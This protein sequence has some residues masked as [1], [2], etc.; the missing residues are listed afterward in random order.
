M[1]M[2]GRN[3]S[4]TSDSYRYAYNGMEHDDEVTSEFG[5]SYTTE[6]RQYDPRL[7]RWKSLDPLMVKYP[8]MSP[9]CA[10]NN[11][12]VYFVDPDGREGQDWFENEKGEKKWIDSKENLEIEVTASGKAHVWT[13]IGEQL[14]SKTSG[15]GKRESTLFGAV[16]DPSNW[17][18]RGS[19]LTTGVNEQ[20]VS[21]PIYPSYQHPL[22]DAAGDRVTSNFSYHAANEQINNENFSDAMLG[23]FYGGE[24]PENFYFG[25]KHSVSRTMANSE[26]AFNAIKDF[27]DLNRGYKPGDPINA[28]QWRHYSQSKTNAALNAIIAGLDPVTRSATVENFIGGA[29]IKIT[30][31]GKASASTIV[32]RVTIVNVT[33]VGSGNIGDGQSFPRPITETLS[34]SPQPFTN[35][36]QTIEFDVI[37]KL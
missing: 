29:T 34:G 17:T 35:I 3:N 16:M 36:S 26:I 12:P 6:F 15:L 7:G 8:S 5:N 32:A 21:P 20:H 11:N 19:F 1:V 28:L 33:S 31:I 18:S 22:G 25:T 9:Y 13:N 4:Y 10:F 24:G 23:A 14:N 2:P 27:Q 30:P 37:I